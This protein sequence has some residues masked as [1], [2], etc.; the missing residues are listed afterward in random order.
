MSGPRPVD[1]LVHRVM[2][3]FFAA[4]LAVRFQIEGTI[5]LE[6]VALQFFGQIADFDVVAS[7]GF[8]DSSGVIHSSSIGIEPLFPANKVRKVLAQAWR[9]EIG[10]AAGKGI[11]YYSKEGKS[12]VLTGSYAGWGTATAY[13]RCAGS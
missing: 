6:A 12:P 3:T 5:Y 10:I 7:S 4:G 8:A 13:S 11:R 1:Q 9:L 2:E